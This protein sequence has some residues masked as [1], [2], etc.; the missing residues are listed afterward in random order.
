MKIIYRT[1]MM[2]VAWVLISGPAGTLYGQYSNNFE[3][4]KNLEI[5]ATL[6]RELNKNYVDEISPGELTQTG[7]DA[8]LETLDPYTVYIPE[9]QV[10]DYRF[11]TTGEY[12]GIGSMIHKQGDWVVISEPYEDNPAMKAG[13]RAG[14]RIVAVDGHSVKGK[15]TSDVSGLLKGE[16]GSEVTVTIQRPGTEQPMDITLKRETVSVKNVPYSGLLDGNIGYIKL[17]GFTRDAASEV[18]KAF[19]SLKNENELKGLILDLKG[20]GGGLLQEAVKIVNLFVEKGEMVVSTRGKLPAKN[21]VYY[22]TDPPVDTEIP[23]VVLVDGASASASEIVAG[24]LQDHDRAVIIGENTFGKGLVQNVIPLAYNAQAKITVAKYYIPSGRCIQELDYQHRDKN[25]KATQIPDSLVTAFKTKN[26]RTVYDGHGIAPD[27]EVERPEMKP[28]IFS[29]ISQFKIF[30]F[31]TQFALQHPAIPSAD[32][33]TV[34]DQLFDEFTNWLSEEN[35]TWENDCDKALEQLRNAAEKSGYTDALNPLLDQLAGQLEELK[36]EDLIA[37][38]KEIEQLLT[39]EI[40]GRYYY[41]TGKIVASL[42][43]DP[44][45][46][47]AKEVLLQ[48]DQYLAIL[49]GTPEGNN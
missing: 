47:R 20:N 4:S 43:M 28:V 10:E 2:L 12:G 39:L 13:L 6:L 15:S 5:Y 17:T 31:A 38:R 29:L 48:R 41:Q 35:F 32:S 26:G 45:I 25:G 42:N 49:S 16:P 27:I 46:T 30:D 24:A 7:I 19:L 34:D 36:S 40:V 18:K 22:T 37:G 3:I 11:M 44:D 8:M 9:S 1:I 33:F 23:L 14:D 21:Q